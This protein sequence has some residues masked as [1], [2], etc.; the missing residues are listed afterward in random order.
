M[1][2]RAVAAT[3]AGALL[4]VCSH[5]LHLRCNTWDDTH[6]RHGL[7][8][9]DVLSAHMQDMPDGVSRIQETRA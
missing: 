7:P 5:L 2:S 8:D 6:C 3:A 1:L 4:P 9:V